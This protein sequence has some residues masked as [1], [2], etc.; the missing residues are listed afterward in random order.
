MSIRSEGIL[1]T[2]TGKT[3]FLSFI[4]L[5]TFP[6]YLMYFKFSRPLVV[7]LCLFTVGSLR[8]TPYSTNNSYCLWRTISVIVSGISRQR[9]R[10]YTTHFK[11]DSYY[12]EPHLGLNSPLH[13]NPPSKTDSEVSVVTPSVSLM[14]DPQV[15]SY[16]VSHSLDDLRF[17][18]S[19][20]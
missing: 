14:V 6:S 17:F 10:L 3:N 11:L 18:L 16:M 20:F 2:T 13:P 4:S 15:N 1:E 7:S 8:T 5:E 9:H 12:P 19:V